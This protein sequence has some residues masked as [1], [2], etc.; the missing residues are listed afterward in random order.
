M[1]K[2]TSTGINTC[3]NYLKYTG[4]YMYLYHLNYDLKCV[5]LAHRVYLCV[6][7]GSHNTQQL[8]P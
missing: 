8:F 6:T 5:C 3:Y 4:N 2:V 7:H 1:L